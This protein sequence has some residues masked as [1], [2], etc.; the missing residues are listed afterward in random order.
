MVATMTMSFTCSD[1]A[2]LLNDYIDGALPQHVRRGAEAHLQTCGECAAGLRDLR[3]T[4][5]LLRRLPREP[6]PDVMKNTLLH[7][8]RSTRPHSDQP[9][10]APPHSHDDP[11]HVQH[12]PPPP[13]SDSTDT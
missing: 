5:R 13:E 10:D 7:A 9:A 11:P 12:S 2:K 3:C 6:M 1:V 4:R 8:L